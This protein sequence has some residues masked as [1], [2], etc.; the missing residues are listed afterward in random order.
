VG[1]PLARYLVLHLLQQRKRK[2]RLE[3]RVLDEPL[4]YRDTNLS[5]P[6]SFAKSM[7]L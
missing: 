3:H 1:Y 4:I 2:Q 6:S 7:V 5:P